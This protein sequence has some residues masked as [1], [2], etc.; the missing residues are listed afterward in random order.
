[1]K[2][3]HRA[4]SLR[5]I[6][7]GRVASLGEL[8]GEPWGSR[9]GYVVVPRTG[10]GLRL[11][12][13]LAPC[14]AERLCGRTVSITAPADGVVTSVCEGR[15]TLRTGDGISVTAAVGEGLRLLTE[16]GQ[17]VRCGDV[18]CTASAQELDRNGFHGALA[19]FFPR[20]DE[21]TELHIFAGC[22]RAQHRTAFYRV[23][24]L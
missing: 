7:N 14:W 6:A 17:Q 16:V 3:S 8:R 5:C 21:I 10:S 13:R 18:I 1:M 24:N 4:R 15:V 23:R 22:R 2:I 19:V 20:P 9:C 12:R 11:L